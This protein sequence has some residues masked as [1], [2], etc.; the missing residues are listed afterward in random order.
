MAIH[1]ENYKAYSKG[2]G[3]IGALCR[4]VSPQAKTTRWKATDCPHCKA[5]MIGRRVIS[6]AGEIGN[7]EIIRHAG[8]EIRMDGSDVIEIVSLDDFDRDWAPF[9]A[10]DEIF[11]DAGESITISQNFEITQ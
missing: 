6:R 8:V 3:F 1:Y 11:P 5:K 9:P 7:V 10:M 4:P 2:Q